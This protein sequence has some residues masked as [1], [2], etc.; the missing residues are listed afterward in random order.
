MLALLTLSRKEEENVKILS[1]P[2]VSQYCKGHRFV[3]NF[4]RFLCLYFSIRC[5]KMK[6]S[7]EWNGGMVL[8]N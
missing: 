2:V 1:S 3:L 8:T 7:S 5:V 6:K 4:P